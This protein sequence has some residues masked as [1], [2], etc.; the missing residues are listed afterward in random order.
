MEKVTG[1]YLYLPVAGSGPA[2]FH[3]YFFAPSRVFKSPYYLGV[4]LWKT[5]PV[6]VQ[7]SAR[8]TDLKTGIKHVLV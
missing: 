7:M 6:D 1:V 5:I 4:Q 8:K 3:R 2:F